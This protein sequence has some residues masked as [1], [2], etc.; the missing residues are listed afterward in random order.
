MRLT[1]GKLKV[2]KEWDEWQQSEFTMLDQYEAQGLF[3]APIP[4]TNKDAIFN[5][6]WTCVVKELD[7]HK[8]AQ[9]TCDGSTRGGQVC[10]L[11]FTYTN[12]VD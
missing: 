7:K 9:C 3:G 11:D 1:R 4:A 12:C 6:V 8:K 5:L 2:T 10:V